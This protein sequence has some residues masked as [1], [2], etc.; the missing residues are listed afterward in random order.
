MSSTIAA[1]RKDPLTSAGQSLYGLLGAMQ[2]RTVRAYIVLVNAS[3]EPRT[4]INPQR[5]EHIEATSTGPV[6][7]SFAQAGQSPA[8]VIMEIRRRSGLTWDMMSELFNVSRRT[9]HHW[10][11]GRPP[12]A[13]R[14]RG[15]RKTLQAI[16]YLDEGSQRATHD[17]LLSTQDDGTTPFELLRRG[18]H[19]DVSRMV[20]GSGSFASARKHT[21]LSEEEWEI[22]RPPRPELLVGAISDRP[23]IPVTN[24]RIVRSAKKSKPS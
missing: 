15:I 17:R 19:S 14:E 5:T 21:P 1:T 10:A 4:T 16:R 9:V 22:R 2:P 3:G 20:A 7:E 6:N 8:E 12:S 23:E 13:Y 24:A 18:R 11:N